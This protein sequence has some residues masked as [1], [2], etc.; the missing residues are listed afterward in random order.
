MVYS[1]DID[2]HKSHGTWNVR[3]DCHNADRT[4]LILQTW[5]CLFG[6]PF[7]ISCTRMPFLSFLLAGDLLFRRDI[8]RTVVADHPSE[9]CGGKR[10]PI[11]GVLLWSASHKSSP[12]TPLTGLRVWYAH[13]TI[14]CNMAHGSLPERSEYVCL[15]E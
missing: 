14:F 3:N 10:S 4:R 1:A 11:E 2:N 15:R 5:S 13:Q 8:L 9:R 6:T 7:Y 12:F